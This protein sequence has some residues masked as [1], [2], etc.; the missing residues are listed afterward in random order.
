MVQDNSLATGLPFSLT[1]GM[2]LAHVDLR[3]GKRIA[4]VAMTS[5]VT[6]HRFDLLEAAGK[7]LLASSTNNRIIYTEVPSQP[8]ACSPRCP[9]RRTHRT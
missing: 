3:Q 6:A 5:G 8:T 2:P 9:L 7:L 4:E 1:P